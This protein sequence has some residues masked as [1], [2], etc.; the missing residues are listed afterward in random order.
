V[1]SIAGNGGSVSVRWRLHRRQ[2][3]TP[4]KYGS[5]ASNQGGERGMLVAG[6]VGGLG[7]SHWCGLCRGVEPL[8]LG[9]FI[10]GSGVMS[11]WGRT[12]GGAPLRGCI[13]G[14]CTSPSAPRCAS[15][16]W[17]CML[18]GGGR[19]LCGG[20]DVGG[21]ETVRDPAA[22]PVPEDFHGFQSEGGGNHKVAPYSK[23]GARRLL[24]RRWQR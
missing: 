7:V 22:D 10:L 3:R 24:A 9:I 5:R 23:I 19:P 15:G 13:R 4:S 6:A 16:V 17:Q 20:G 18:P 8:G 21:A 11:M 2:A 1:G 12:R 14:G